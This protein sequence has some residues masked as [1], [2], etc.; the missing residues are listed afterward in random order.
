[1]RSMFTGFPV[2]MLLLGCGAEAPKTP[3]TPSKVQEPSGKML[4]QYSKELAQKSEPIDEVLSK[5]E[6]LLEAKPEDADILGAATVLSYVISNS[7]MRD[8]NKDAASEQ[9]FKTLDFLTRLKKLDKM[10]DEVKPIVSDVYM[11]AANASADQ[12]QTDRAFELLNMAVDAGFV[13]PLIFDFGLAFRKLKDDPRSQELLE[14]IRKSLI[15]FD[16]AV[17]LFNTE[18][19]RVPLTRYHGKVVAAYVWGTWDLPSLTSLRHLNN[20]QTKHADA[21]LQIVGIN[22]ERREPEKAAGV[23]LAFLK[24]RPL[25]FPTFIG[26]NDI[27]KIIPYFA[28]PETIF[29]DRSG[30]VRDRIRG[31]ITER[32]FEK[33]VKPLLAEDTQNTNNADKKPDKVSPADL[34]KPQPK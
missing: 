18:G 2:L 33:I 4:L 20:L 16:F 24:D 32:D 26:P 11:A 15:D 9:A 10:T 25:K 17:T 34:D 6:E 29:L 19:K 14:K 3:V 30:R 12:G 8:G 22:I 28:F 23:I 7:A 13:D 21:G 1:M 5:A 31:P 27:P